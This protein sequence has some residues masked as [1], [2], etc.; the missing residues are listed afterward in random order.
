MTQPYGAIGYMPMPSSFPHRALFLAGRPRHQRFD[1]FWRK[2]PPMDL[3][4]RAKIFSPFDALAGFDE[5]I[6]EKEV[7]YT[8]KA[9]LSDYEKVKLDQTINDLHRLTF[10]S[11]IAR[12]NRVFVEVTY[13]VPCTDPNHDAYGSGG[14]YESISGMVLR[15][16]MGHILLRT[17]EGEKTIPFADIRN[18]ERK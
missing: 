9:S 18:I 7:L 6:A 15:V 10:N 2:H 14:R 12:E 1:D 17:N 13:F 3:I 4:H 11:R 8:E 5:R 16:E